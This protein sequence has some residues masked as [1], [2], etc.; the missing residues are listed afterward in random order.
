MVASPCARC[1]RTTSVAT[2]PAPPS[3]SALG[4]TADG[5]GVGPLCCLPIE[6]VDDCV[7]AGGGCYPAAATGETC[8]AG[9]SEIYSAC[10]NGDVCCGPG[11]ACADAG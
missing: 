1:D 2:I 3:D 9:W 11:I 10:S 7:N 5:D 8:P 4:C 6:T